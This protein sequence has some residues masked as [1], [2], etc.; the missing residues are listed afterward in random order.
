[1]P[2]V[3]LS[4]LSLPPW[5]SV[6]AFTFLSATENSSRK[7]GRKVEVLNTLILTG[8]ASLPFQ[9]ARQRGRTVRLPWTSDS[10]EVA[11]CIRGSPHPFHDHLYLPVRSRALPGHT[12]ERTLGGGGMA[13]GQIIH[14]IKKFRHLFLKFRQLV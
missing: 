4:S 5:Q 14:G 11:S 13:E 9:E 3:L 12:G 6:D 7:H 2:P 10:S 8:K 1:M